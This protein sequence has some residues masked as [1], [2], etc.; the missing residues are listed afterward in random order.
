LQM[1]L[2]QINILMKKA[3]IKENISQTPW[4]M[5]LLHCRND[6]FMIYLQV[7]V[8]DSYLNPK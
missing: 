4:L 6:P 2:S 1:V 3:E 8:F 5:E 7:C